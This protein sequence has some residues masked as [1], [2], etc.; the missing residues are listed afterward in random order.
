MAVYNGEAYLD[1]ALLALIDG[2]AQPSH[3][4][5]V[6]DGSTDRS[7]DRVR[8][9]Q[10]RCVAAGITLELIH[11]ANAGQ[12]AAR[13]RGLEAVTEAHVMFFDQDDRCTR[14]HLDALWTE[15]ETDTQL[16]WCT[17]GFA[18]IDHAGAVI[19]PDVLGT[20]GYRPPSPDVPSFLAQ[21]LMMLP[22][23]TIIQTAAVRA[24][25]GFDTQFRGYEDDDLFTRLL[26]A[27]GRYRFR[28]AATLHYRLHAVNSSSA[29]TYR[30]S[31]MRFFDKWIAVLDAEPGRR[32]V[33]ALS[34]RMFRDV[35]DDL[36]RA[37]RRGDQQVSRE[38]ARSLRHI[39]SRGAL[40]ARSKWIVNLSRSPLLMRVVLRLWRLV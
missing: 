3:I 5:V 29:P 4:V 20:A 2:I 8:A 14:D 34:E 31:R 25:S 26:A 13:N 17:A 37:E 9:W 32:G 10:P 6:D 1:E 19:D 23:A 28:P 38:S 12:S 35:L 22:S 18:T 39:A 24:V 30:A 11:Q 27:G 16:M 15:L 33:N 7:V 36:V 40:S 21:N